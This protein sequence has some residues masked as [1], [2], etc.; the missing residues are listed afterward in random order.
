MRTPFVIQSLAF[1]IASGCAS[2]S[3]AAPNLVANGD[4]E[5]G[6]TAFTS[7]YAFAPGG[8]GTEGQYTVRANPFPWNG[9]F[10]SAADHTSG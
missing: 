8:N 9:L 10:I 5:A 7:G 4:F 1:V 3:M 6:N 2:A